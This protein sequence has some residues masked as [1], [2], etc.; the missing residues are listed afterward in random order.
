MRRI[1]RETRDLSQVT[2][3]YSPQNQPQNQR[4]EKFQN[5]PRMNHARQRLGIWWQSAAT[6]PPFP[7]SQT[8]SKF[9]DD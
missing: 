4:G 2:R 3:S 1:S 7:A 8:D 6:T 5:E 9:F